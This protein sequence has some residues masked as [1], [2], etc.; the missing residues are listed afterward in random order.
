[1]TELTELAFVRLGVALVGVAD[2][3]ERSCPDATGRLETSK[4]MEEDDCDGELENRDSG[5]TISGTCAPRT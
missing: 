4:R 5:R 2:E 3:E 1:M